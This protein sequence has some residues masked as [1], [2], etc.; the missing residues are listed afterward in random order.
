MASHNKKNNIVD[1][2]KTSRFI[3]SLSVLLISVFFVFSLSGCSKGPK[4]EEGDY[5]YLSGTQGLEMQFMD[6]MPSPKI[7]SGDKLQ[8]GIIVRNKGTAPL[9]GILYLEGYDRK[10]ITGGQLP[11]KTGERF[12]K[13][14]QTIQERGLYNNIGGEDYLIFSSN[15]IQLDRSIT[16]YPFTLTAYACYEYKTTAIA[17]VCL[18]PKPHR[19]NADKPCITKD[20]S[21]GTQG[22]PVAVNAVKVD[23]IGDSRVRLVFQFKNVGGGD[24]V[25]LMQWEQLCPTDFYPSDFNL[26]YVRVT[27]VGSGARGLT[28]PQLDSTNGVVRLDQNG[29][30]RLV[31]N[32]DIDSDAA[33]SYLSSIRVEAEYAYRQY[34][35]KQVEIR[36]Q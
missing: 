7:Y 3:L 22:A 20:V 28:C 35:K 34:I 29:Q 27:P 36:A 2:G 24:I 5:Y 12:P 4:G 23:P 18:D 17:T 13:S 32:L 33:S 11:R 25:D 15:P 21:L 31:C 8:V 30:G 16:T 10:I 26:L 14:G 9:A 1:N 19:T 6:G